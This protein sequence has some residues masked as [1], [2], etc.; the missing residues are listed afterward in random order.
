MKI[1]SPIIFLIRFYKGAISP[2]TMASCRYEPTCSSYTIKALEKHGIFYGG[3]LGIKRILSCN[4]FGG[5]GYDP[6]P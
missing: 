6:V 5:K 2:L 4:P 3:Y 1:I